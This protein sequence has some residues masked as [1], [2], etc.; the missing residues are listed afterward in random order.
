MQELAKVGSVNAWDVSKWG[1]K[2][3]PF[4]STP[5]VATPKAAETTSITDGIGYG[6]YNRVFSIN[7]DGEKDLGEIGPIRKYIIDHDALR[8]RSWQ[9]FL[10]SDVS[11]ALFKRSAIWG[12]GT[13]LKLQAEPVTEVLETDDIEIDSEEFNEEIEAKFG[14]YASSTMCDYSGN[15]NLHQIANELW[16]N[17]DV[18]GDT[19]FIMRLV[20][21]MPKV[22]IVDGANVRTP[23]AFG[24]NTGMETINPDT[25][26]VIRR[27][28]ELDKSGRHVAYWVQKAVAGEY[29]TDYERVLTR[30]DKY[31]YSETARLVYGLKYRIDNVRGIPLITAVM[32]TAAKMARYREATLG[33]AEERA[34][35]AYTIEHEAFSTG[36]NPIVSQMAV[37][38]GFGPQTDLPTDSQG[39][40]LENRVAAT[41]NK[42]AVNMPLG[43][44]LKA[45]DSKQEINFKDF[46]SV[47][48]DIV[49]A[50]AGYPPE[51]ILSKYD[52][53]YSA[54]RAAI[55]DFEHTL[56]VKREAFAAQF[57]QVVYNFCLDVWALSGSIEVPGY[58]SALATQNEMALAA[59]RN[60]RWAGDVV[61]HIDPMKEVAAWRA[62]LGKD[63]E[64]F[65]LCTIEEATEA[66]STSD[67]SSNLE[68][69]SREIEKG[70]S[71]GI[72][73]VEPKQPAGEAPPPSE[74]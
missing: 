36:E 43:A 67:Y 4:P 5:I 52:S 7:Y 57:Y 51:V 59:Y 70:V 61:P 30:M 33:G 53:N 15:R 32:E 8:L 17:D 26:N 56:L 1:T 73:L 49:C 9:L 39:A 22:Q 55:K 58:L 62:K 63:S 42:Q 3:I 11:Q 54:S 44:K 25:K 48:F 24:T 21:G 40:A 12:V 19:L 68:Q 50:V 35:I 6:G 16:I 47:N 10:E 31:P 41:A 64:N 65:P 18:G 69:Y 74:D 66:L 72:K 60:A 38:S 23:M 71:M 13:G 28:V 2:V 46:Y 27:G 14:L 34:K 37:A 29:I 20:N 45:T